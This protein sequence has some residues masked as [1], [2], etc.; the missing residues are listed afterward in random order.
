MT[1]DVAYNSDSELSEAS[2]TH[3]SS[4]SLQYSSSSFKEGSSTE[5]E[6]DVRRDSGSGTIE[7]YQYE[8]EISEEDSTVADSG[9]ADGEIEDS[10]I[11]RLHNTS[12]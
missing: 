9:S 4:L 3:S 5:L 8:P 6:E 10:L 11:E 7:P 2:D 1:M 12:W